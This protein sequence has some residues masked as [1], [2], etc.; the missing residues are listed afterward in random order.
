M[1][2]SAGRLPFEFPDVGRSRLSGDVRLARRAAA[3]DQKAFAA[4]FRRHHQELYRYCCAI[5]RDPEDAQDALQATMVKALRAL[6]GETREIA[7]KPWLFRIAHN[8]AISLVRARRDSADLDP[9]QPD[10]AAT[11]EHHASTRD[12]LRE[13]MRDLDHLPARQRGALV[14]RELN[15]LS[16]EDIG[17][18]LGMRP[19]AAKQAVYEARTALMAMSEGREMDCDPVGEAISA[20][21]RRVLRGRRIRAH[22]RGCRS[23]RDFEAAISHRRTD[24]AALAP[25]VALPAAM[26][27]LQAIFGASGAV[28]GG[29][30]AATAGAGAAA[31]GVGGLGGG[32]AIKAAVAVLATATVAGGAAGLTGVV[33]LGGGSSERATRSSE[34]SP[35]TAGPAADVPVSAAPASTAD[36]GH[37]EAASGQDNRGDRSGGRGERG[38]EHGHSHSGGHPVTEPG[39]PQG[40]ANGQ[41]TAPGQTSTSG[42]SPAVPPGQS[43]TA[44]GQSHAGSAGSQESST[45]QSQSSNIGDSQASSTGQA[46]G[47]GTAPTPGQTGTSPGQSGNSASL[48]GHDRGMSSSS[49]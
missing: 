23:C 5:L 48:P 2:E 17:R 39:S 3:G 47:S 1:T 7:L 31:G 28:S 43:G 38:P 11:V 20:Q 29:A 27:T 15:G 6:P 42:N 24:L 49:R 21:D 16:F 12:R 4:I 44:P 40:R 30:G 18:A 26:A 13:L 10:P 36:P 46:Q 22:L 35:S 33:D 14:M 25:P 9:E 37:S 45:G 32:V 8:E 41:A 19:A 34:P